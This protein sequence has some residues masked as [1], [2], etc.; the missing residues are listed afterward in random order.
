MLKYNKY[1]LK[2][3]EQSL[4]Q[5]QSVLLKVATTT[6]TITETLSAERY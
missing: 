4:Y 2:I 6:N 5:Q 1:F 3:V